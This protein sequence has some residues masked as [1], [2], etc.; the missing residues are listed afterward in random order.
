MKRLVE[1]QN[2][3]NRKPLLIRGARQVGKTYSIVEFG[4][5]HFKGNVHILNFEKNPDIHSIFNQN[6]DSVRILS[7]LELILN[8]HIKSGIDLLFFDEIQEC[9]K[10]IMALRYF[11]EQIPSLHVIAAGSLLEFAIED[12]S[13]PVGRLQMLYMQPMTFE[14]FL[15]AN[16]KELLAEKIKQPNIRLSASVLEIVNDELYTYFIIGGMP[17]CVKIYVE[18]GSLLDPI[19][20]QTDLIATF[21]QDFSKYAGHSDKRCLNSVLSS[22][23]SRIGEQIKYSQLA[24]NYSNPTIK[25]AFELLETARLFTKVRAVSPGGIPLGANASDKK[26]KVVFL[27]IG[28]LSNLSGFYSDKTVSKQKLIAS[29]RG[30][31]A[32]QFVGQELRAS[33]HED[34]YY[35]SR[36]VPGS[37][38]E[39]DYFIEKEGEIIPIEV[40]SGR[41]GSLKSLH[42]LLDT[43]TNIKTAFV[44]TEDKYGELP[45]QKIKFLPMFYASWLGLKQKI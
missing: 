37:S 7:E 15:I 13:F 1:W 26:F 29:F 12:I 28:M 44:F 42:I 4:K 22:V 17:E 11:Y 34:L 43:F 18:T 36:D 16:N 45:E 23:A 20:I 14:E 30:K 25:K 19:N 3:A 21:R 33:V 41:S 32:E 6:L 2:K 9:P 24:E 31:M 40:K 5:T 10:A 27:D 8:K 38:A 35:W 39:T